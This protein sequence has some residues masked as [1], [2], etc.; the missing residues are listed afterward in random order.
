MSADERVLFAI[1]AR[2][3]LTA[4]TV[5]GMSTREVDGWIRFFGWR[6]AASANDDDALPL[7]Q[8]PR[9]TLRQMFPG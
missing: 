5:E 9:E 6:G 3:G 2:L 7:G 4:A 1:G 8:V